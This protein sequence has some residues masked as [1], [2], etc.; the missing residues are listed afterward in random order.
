MEFNNVH[1]FQTSLY[2][3]NYKKLIK[4]HRYDV[5]DK[6]DEVVEKLSRGEISS[7]YHNHPLTNLKVNDIHITGDVI[8][9]YR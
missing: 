3:K 5:V 2:S 9:L 8:L 6:V 4:Q 1:I 7:Q